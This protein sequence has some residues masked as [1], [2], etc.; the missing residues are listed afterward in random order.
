MCLLLLL[1]LQTGRSNTIDTHIRETLHAH[2]AV[3]SAH[4]HPLLGKTQPLARAAVEVHLRTHDG[5][6]RRHGGHAAVQVSTRRSSSGEGDLRRRAV[7]AV[8]GALQV[9][10]VEE[11]EVLDGLLAL[12]EHVDDVLCQAAADERGR[13]DDLGADVLQERAQ[14]FGFERFGRQLEFAGFGRGQGGEVGE[15]LGRVVGEAGVGALEV[16][17]GAQAGEEG[18]DV[19][20]LAAVGEDFGRERGGVAED[21]GAVG[22][23]FGDDFGRFA[24]GFLFGGGGE[25]DAGDGFGREVGGDVG[26]L[27]LD[28]EVVLHQVGEDAAVGAVRAGGVEGSACETGGGVDDAEGVEVV[29]AGD[30][31][32][33]RRVV[34]LVFGQEIC[35]AAA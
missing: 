21:E 10:A 26:L 14:D 29:I 7:E 5:I 9:L 1:L 2:R 22:F 16:E 34:S 23:A 33:V 18:G 3:H 11:G 19:L 12:A 27:A 31:H 13:G 6:L 4:V 8:D 28:D 35:E 20:Q 15:V 17:E 24:V 32:G 25:D 30:D